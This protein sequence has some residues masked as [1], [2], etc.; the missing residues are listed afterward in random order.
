MTKAEAMVLAK[1]G[2]SPITLK[3]LRGARVG[4]FGCFLRLP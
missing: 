4:A 1:W 2:M 3:P